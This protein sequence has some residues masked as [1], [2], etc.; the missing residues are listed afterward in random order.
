MTDS[1]FNRNN[2][3]ETEYCISA[4]LLIFGSISSALMEDAPAIDCDWE[5]W[6]YKTV[7]CDCEGLFW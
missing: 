4:H 5:R 2:L 6:E 1:H 7:L 3:E